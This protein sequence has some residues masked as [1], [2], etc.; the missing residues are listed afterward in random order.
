MKTSQTSLDWLMGDTNASTAALYRPQAAPTQPV[1]GPNI[2]MQMA[3]W[4]ANSQA[5]QQRYLNTKAAQT[6]FA[7][8]GAS[9]ALARSA[10]TIPSAQAMTGSPYQAGHYP[11]NG[12]SA[13]NP[14]AQTFLEHD[15][16]KYH[17]TAP[18]KNPVQDIRFTNQPLHAPAPE[19]PPINGVRPDLTGMTGGTAHSSI[20][21]QGSYPGV[22]DYS[23]AAPIVQSGDAYRSIVAGQP[24]GAGMP[25]TG[26]TNVPVVDGQQG[27]LSKG[28]DWFTGLFDN[29][30]DETNTETGVTKK[31]WG[32]PAIN[33]GLGIA[34]TY[35]GYDQ[36]KT[37]KDQ[38]A[39]NM[40]LAWS[41]F[42]EQQAATSENV[43]NRERNRLSGLGKNID[44]ENEARNRANTYLTRK[45]PTR[46]A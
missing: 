1:Y 10:A 23:T 6:Q 4:D 8:A 28:W 15:I 27:M 21:M 24:A 38:H 19:L 46:S 16:A 26:A 42:R 41:N 18:V 35:L 3:Q 17:T 12:S 34:N 11:G 9:E 39:D 44:V 36:L 7:S 5:A 14:T 25:T 2:L 30:W 37:A 20:P 33:A 40:E 32:M 13:I 31:G 22:V 29:F 45:M 43:F